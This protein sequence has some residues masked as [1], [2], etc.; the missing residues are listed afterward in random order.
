MLSVLQ[1]ENLAEPAAFL[2]G[3]LGLVWHQNR[4]TNR[5]RDEFHG[6]RKET[7]ED[8]RDL[9]DEFDGARKETQQAIQEL[10]FAVGENGQR[11]S[12]IEGFLGIGMPGS[13]THNPIGAAKAAEQRSPASAIQGTHQHQ[14]TPL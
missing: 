1:I 6:A 14:D 10:Q 2:V 3:V 13:A 12:R 11:L 7:R 8:I 5:L 9:R 4:G